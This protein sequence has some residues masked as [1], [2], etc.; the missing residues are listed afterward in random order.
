MAALVWFHRWIGVATCLIFAAWFASGAILLF[1]PFPSLSHAERLEY[2]APVATSM[3]QVAPADAI[4]A[5][6][7][8]GVTS[9]RLIQRDGQ[10]VYVVEGGQRAITVD[11]RTGMVLP[12]LK[13]KAVGAGNPAINYDQWIVHNSFDPYR[14]IYRLPR[15]DAG[16]TTLYISA[17]T[18]EAVQRTTRSDRAWNWAGAVLHWVY[19]TPLR[20]S[21]TAWD[22]TVWTISLITMLVATA[23]IVLGVIRTSTALAQRK[24]SLSFYRLKWMR[25]HHLLG[26]FSS[27][28]VLTWILSGWLSMDHGRIF[29]RGTST[30]AQAAA[31]QGEP[32]RTTLASVGTPVI[33]RLGPTRE[34]QFNAVDGKPIL[35]IFRSDGR[36]DR[37]DASGQPLS[38]G[39][40]RE[41]V[42]AG[43]QAAWPGS[44][45]ER[46]TPVAPTDFYAQAEGWPEGTNRAELTGGSYPDVYFDSRTGRMLTVMDDSRA[47]YEWVYYA[48]HTFKFPGLAER[49]VLRQII[50]LIPLLAGFAFSITGVVIGWKRIRRFQRP[51]RE[52]L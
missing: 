43:L 38:D 2:A 25:W 16:G 1:K 30:A 12:L 34:I 13:P 18:G 26:L 51:L 8:E 9:V 47:S 33:E 5:S 32:F 15:N 36:T 52:K 10:P 11:A 50:V 42:S 24:P 49:P 31:Y 46:V 22:R 21:F 23:G 29:A 28:F 44:R 39:T 35:T 45:V 17:R 4:A 14:P 7:Q 48:L 27:L 40:F 6:R 41:R 20:A 3:V 37:L 19:F